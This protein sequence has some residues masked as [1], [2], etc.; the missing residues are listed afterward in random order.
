MATF[1]SSKVG[2]RFKSAESAKRW[3]TLNSQTPGYYIIYSD[4][5]QGRFFRR[6]AITS[7]VVKPKQ[8]R[9]RLFFT[10]GDP[11]V[12]VRLTFAYIELARSLGYQTPRLVESADGSVWAVF[13]ARAKQGW[14]STKA[15][16]AANVVRRTAEAW[17]VDRPLANNAAKEMEA[18]ANFLTAIES[19]GTVSADFGSVVIGQIVDA[20]GNRHVRVK[21]FSAKELAEQAYSDEL[22][23]EPRD[24]W[25]Q[26]P[27]A[28]HEK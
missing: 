26:L 6:G 24:L 3:I 25:K 20:D 16:R 1:R 13:K 17:G 19:A 4:S 23:K 5:P 15:R 11:L 9:L 2:K 10:G 12:A 21:T 14:E 22:M 28:P 18:A 7:V 27:P 8:Y